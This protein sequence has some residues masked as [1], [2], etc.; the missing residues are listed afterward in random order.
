MT[1]VD[2]ATEAQSPGRQCGRAGTWMMLAGCVRVGTEL[3]EE[4]LTGGLGHRVVRSL[5]PAQLIEG[6]QQD[7]R[8]IFGFP[9]C[10]D[11]VESYF[12]ARLNLPLVMETARDDFCHNFYIF[13]CSC[14][15]Q[16]F[17]AQDTRGS[18]P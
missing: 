17:H 18:Q 7:S 13:L 5:P 9:V 1:L 2:K 15:G 12:F 8:Q 11:M 16:H 14:V 4:V 3:G 10:G 6:G